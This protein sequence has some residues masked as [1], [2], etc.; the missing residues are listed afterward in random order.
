V[1]VKS[2]YHQSCELLISD[3]REKIYAEQKLNRAG[4]KHVDLD[5]VFDL[6]K[7]ESAS[8]RGLVQLHLVCYDRQYPSSFMFLAAIKPS[9]GE[10][11][12]EGSQFSSSV[13]KFMSLCLEELESRG[14]KDPLRA[15]IALA[16][17][18]T[19]EFAR[20]TN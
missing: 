13:Q 1:N 8:E 7:V 3:L 18:A 9:T 15:G 10:W 19:K 17:I 2:V 14:E 6:R 11:I 5:V 20:L 16:Q 4:K 12:T